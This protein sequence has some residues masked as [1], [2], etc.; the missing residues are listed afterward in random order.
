MPIAPASQLISKV[1][2][3]SLVVVAVVLHK[4]FFLAVGRVGSVHLPT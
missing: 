4:V 2:P 1:L 3:K